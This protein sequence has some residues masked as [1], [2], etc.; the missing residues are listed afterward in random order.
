MLGYCWSVQY[1]SFNFAIE[2]MDSLVHST[3]HVYRGF[4][5]HIT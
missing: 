3:L 1:T 5:E 2:F 4:G